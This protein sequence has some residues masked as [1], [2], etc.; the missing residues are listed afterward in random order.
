M[1]YFLLIPVVLVA[2]L[3]GLIYLFQEKLIF[4]PQPLKRDYVFRFRQPFEE[5]FLDSA[6]G[7][8]VLHALH[9]KTESPK[10]VVLYFHGNAGNLRDWGH[11]SEDFLPYGY[12]VFIIDYRMYGKSTGKLSE[13]ALHLDARM[14]FNYVKQRFPEGKVLVYG[15]S[16]GT[17]LAVKLAAEN[18]VDML[19]LET[20]YFH[21]ADVGQTHYPWLPAGLLLRYKFRNDEWIKKVKCPVYIF[22]GT[23]DQVVPYSSGKKLADIAGSNTTLI[24]I[25][26][27]N[28]NNLSQFDLYHQKMAELMK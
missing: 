26:G 16:L 5:V 28:H 9:F 17:G 25:P 10:G 6:A 11:V 4:F 27:G 24:T 7:G 13:D 22:H 2:L 23:A 21:F 15:R 20:P 1:F 12:D 18:N 14:A 8:T 19:I 3:L